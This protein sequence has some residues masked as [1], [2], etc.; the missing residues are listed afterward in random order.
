MWHD[1]IWGKD[2]WI[3]QLHE[4]VEGRDFLN[5]CVHNAQ[6]YEFVCI[7]NDIAIMNLSGGISHFTPYATMFILILF[8]VCLDLYH[9]VIFNSWR[10]LL[11]TERVSQ[12]RN[13]AGHHVRM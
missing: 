11:W 4:G 1:F 3:L 2:T 7:F 8:F 9:I 12:A 5:T 13:A 6:N 10:I